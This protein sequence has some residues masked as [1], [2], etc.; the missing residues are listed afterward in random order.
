[1]LEYY[2][3]STKQSQNQQQQTSNSKQ[4]EETKKQEEEDE[5]AYEENDKVKE[6]DNADDAADLQNIIK[7]KKRQSTI[8]YSQRMLKK[9]DNLTKFNRKNHSEGNKHISNNDL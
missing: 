6:L 8:T 3:Q 9:A 2:K 7:Q 4:A 1:M 5:E